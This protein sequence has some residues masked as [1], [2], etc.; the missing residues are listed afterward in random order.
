MK[1]IKRSMREKCKNEECTGCAQCQTEPLNTL[2]IS[3]AFLRKTIYTKKA[4]FYSSILSEHRPSLGIQEKKL[5]ESPKSMHEEKVLSSPRPMHILPLA[6]GHVNSFSTGPSYSQEKESYLGTRS[7]AC[8]SA[9]ALEEKP[10]PFT[11]QR[12]GESFGLRT[13]PISGANKGNYWNTEQKPR[14]DRMHTL[15]NPLTSSIYSIP[16]TSQLKT[17][18]ISGALITSLLDETQPLIKQHTHLNDVLGLPKIHSQH[19]NLTKELLKAV[20][21]CGGL[22]MVDDSS[23]WPYISKEISHQIEDIARLRMYYIIICYPFEQLLLLRKNLSKDQISS[24]TLLLVYVD[25]KK[26]DILPDIISALVQKKKKEK[27]VHPVKVTETSGPSEVACSLNYI[28]ALDKCQTEELLPII[29]QMRNIVCSRKEVS[30]LFSCVELSL[31]REQMQKVMNTWIVQRLLEMRSKECVQ[32]ICAIQ[33]YEKYLM[34]RLLS[35]EKCGECTKKKEI[36]MLYEILSF[37]SKSLTLFLSKNSFMI[38]IHILGELPVEE[39]SYEKRGFQRVLLCIWGILKHSKNPEW[40]TYIKDLMSH[41]L[42]APVFLSAE[43]LLKRPI[44][45]REDMK[46]LLEGGALEGVLQILM[47]P[48][49]GSLLEIIS[50][51]RLVQ[52]WRRLLQGILDKYF[53]S[54]SLLSLWETAFSSIDIL[55]GFLLKHLEKSSSEERKELLLGFDLENALWLEPSLAIESLPQSVYFLSINIFSLESLESQNTFPN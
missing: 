16:Q 24:S 48:E 33:E 15:Y 29:M 10:E 34:S 20:I 2:S 4:S 54:G 51:K 52:I 50:A 37:F 39:L 49:A 44:L 1:N 42:V 55:S 26:N 25:P 12:F 13:H 27:T 28:Y 17:T 35:S 36:E 22:Q 7:P 46:V 47:Y 8:I 53:S 11:S 18:K 31:F 30:S 23:L 43:E 38:M 40:S 9:D 5:M 45:N 19:V 41:R 14:I 3:D 32:E 6:P 21:S